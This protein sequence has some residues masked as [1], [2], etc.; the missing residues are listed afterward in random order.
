MPTLPQPQVHGQPHMPT[1]PTPSDTAWITAVRN[2][3]EL[4]HAKLP[5]AMHGRLE[6]ATALAI[7][8]GVWMEDDGVTS[9]VKGSK[10]GIWYVVNGHCQ[11]EDYLRAPDGRCKHRCARWIY[12]KAS[13]RL[14]ASGRRGEEKKTRLPA[15]LPPSP[16]IPPKYLVIINNK[17]FVKYAGLLQMA[18]A[19]GLVELTAHWTFNSDTLSLAM[20]IAIFEDGNRFEESGD[21]APENVAG[22]IRA[23]WRRMA[24]T[25]AK[26]RALR[27]ALNI[28]ECSVEELADAEPEEPTIEE[29]GTRHA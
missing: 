13:E 11:C 19:R 20:A 8:H 14:R 28:A 5:E 3:S 27:D 2:V 18:H 15:P 17:P 24:L 12:L 21:S 9:Q 25:R 22:P 1:A 4:A 26:A 6:R 29:E 16:T 7:T 23:S 10:A